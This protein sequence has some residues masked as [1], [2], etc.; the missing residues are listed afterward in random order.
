[1][2]K[3][4]IV[5]DSPVIR[6][7][8]THILDSDPEI[9]VIGIASDGE[10]ALTFLEKQRPDVI[11]MDIYMPK[12]NGLEVTRR[13]MSTTP[14]PIVIV[15]GNL[16]RDEVATTFRSIEA[17][18]LAAIPRPMGIG[19][20]DHEKTVHSLVRTV[21]LMSEIKVVKR[22]MRALRKPP[23]VAIPQQPAKPKL[24]PS[25][26]LKLIAIGASTG[27]PNA[28]QAVLSGLPKEFALPILIVQH[29]ATG[30]ILGFAEWLTQVTPFPVHVATHGEQ[31][32]PGHVYVAPDGRHMEISKTTRI[33][34]VDSP[35]ENGL[36]PAVSSLLRSVALNVGNSAIGILLTGM[37][38]DGAQELKLMKEVGA[39]T[40]A[41]DKN[42]S[43]VHGMPGSAIDMGAA[44]YVLSLEKI[45]A[46]LVTLTVNNR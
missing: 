31:V 9:Q 29:M 32:I 21:K 46:E 25:A 7:F 10:Q 20:P 18:A 8:L 41:Q 2:I 11:T 35:P 36:R 5:E 34:L 39:I 4:L 38:Q 6:E 13:I 1:M 33:Q 24:K 15:S 30:F 27:G 28:V 14:V 40:I 43:V 23:G 22:R 26:P 3:V 44:T 16:D 12:I 19:H 37:G 17:G 45:A 42:S